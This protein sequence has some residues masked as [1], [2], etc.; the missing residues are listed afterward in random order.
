M[1]VRGQGHHHER[2]NKLTSVAHVIRNRSSKQF[3]ACKNLDSQ[4]RWCL[5]GTPIQ[6]RLDDLASLV[7]FLKIQPF[8]SQASFQKLIL[9]PLENDSPHRCRNIELL[10][11][12]LFLR[13]DVSHLKLPEIIDVDETIR[14]T[15]EER[16]AYTKIMD[17]SRLELEREV[18][19]TEKVLN[20]YNVMFMAMHKLRRCCNSGTFRIAD[21]N[22]TECNT[23]NTSDVDML[24]LLDSADTCPDCGK[25]LEGFS[26]ASSMASTPTDNS[27]QSKS[28]RETASG[29]SPQAC[30][31]YS[32]KLSKVVENITRQANSDKRQAHVLLSTRGPAFL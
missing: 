18:C 17:E 25:T 19:K 24:A 11:R 3:K 5:T 12:S 4:R 26:P 7:A 28:R 15:T 23:C 8:E 2:I 1:K 9:D 31:G 32:S 29:P 21:A 20:R 22:A 16:A 6:N 14:L 30:N 27:S 10:L 13:R